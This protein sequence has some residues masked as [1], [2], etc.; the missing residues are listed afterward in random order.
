MWNMVS[1]TLSNGAVQTYQY[2]KNN[3]LSEVKLPLGESFTYT[4][5]AVGNLIKATC[6]GINGEEPQNTEYTWDLEG[7][8]ASVT[9]P[10][11]NTE[12]YLYNKNG[13]LISKKDRDGYET[14]ISYGQNGKVEEILYA[15]AQ[16]VSLSYDALRRLKEIKDTLGTTSILTDK[17]GRTVSVTDSFGKTV[18]YEWGSMGE[19]KTVIYPDGKRAEYE[20]NNGM[21]LEALHMGNETIRYAYDAIGQLCEKILPNG[22]I[23]SYHYNAY[24]RVDEIRHE[25]EDISERYSYNFDVYGNKIGTEKKRNGMDADNG[26]YSYAYDEMSRLT[27]VRQNNELLRKYAYDAFGNRIQK[28]EYTNGTEKLTNYVY[29]VNNQLMSETDAV[30]TKNYSYDNRGNLLKVTSGAEVLKEFVF[31][32]SNQMTLAT[33]MVDGIKKHAEY[34]YNGLGQRLVQ[35]IYTAV[36]EN[37]EKKIQYT[38]DMTRQYYNLLQMNETEKAMQTYYWDGNVTGVEADGEQS[39]YLQDDLGSPMQLLNM[40]WTGRFVSEDKVRGT[41]IIPY[42]LNHYSYCWNDS[43]DF[44]DKDGNIPTVVIGAG[45]GL[46]GIAATTG[47]TEMGGNIIEQGVIEK[48][49]SIDYVE[50][51]KETVN[52]SVLQ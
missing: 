10:L 8:I 22:I 13:N 41:I 33:G 43:E 48:R 7:H 44:I 14:K 4:Y 40:A 17:M 29:N 38:L 49:E 30:L 42:T 11:G 37:P 1:Q 3:R 50:D 39:F 16:K 34:R 52:C 27:E 5:D 31:D 36:P 21:Q 25:S 35:S 51:V 18:G 9:D 2:D 47:V 20:Y 23:T 26:I 32:A 46:L 19:K 12:S 45:V 15:D 24:G 28:A 6:T